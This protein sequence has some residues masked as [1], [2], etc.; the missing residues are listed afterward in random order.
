MLEWQFFGYQY[1]LTTAI[2]ICE[3][4]QPH[5][6][7]SWYEIMTLITFLLANRLLIGGRT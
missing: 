2:A 4:H 3:C 1:G 7:R 5:F 6:I